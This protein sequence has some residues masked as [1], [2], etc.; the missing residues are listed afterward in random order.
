MA[1]LVAHVFEAEVV[2]EA[3]AYPLGKVAEGLARPTGVPAQQLQQQV[4][5][6]CDVYLRFH[7][8]GAGAR[9]GLHLQVLFE[10]LE[11]HLDGPPVPVQSANGLGRPSEVVGYQLKGPVFFRIVHGHLPQGVVRHPALHGPFPRQVYLHVR[12]KPRGR[13]FGQRPF[14]HHLVGGV[15]LDARHEVVPRLY[16][17][18]HQQ[19]V[20]VG[21]VLHYDVALL[22]HLLREAL[23]VVHPC[24]GY[25]HHVRQHRL[26]VQA[27]MYLYTPLCCPELCPVKQGQAE[28]HRGAVGDLD[29]FVLDVPY[30]LVGQALGLKD[31]TIV[32]QQAE[33]QVLEHPPVPLAVAVA[34]RR[35]GG[36]LRQAQVG[37]E[38][39]AHPYARRYVLQRVAPV[40]L[41]EHLGHQLVV[42]QVT[43]AVL[44][45]PVAV[46]G[47]LE[48]VARDKVD[49]LA[50]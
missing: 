1:D 5:Y 6:Q 16:S 33:V 20:V 25:V 29:R 43:A 21:P 14:G 26:A 12:D 7:G 31:A 32:P 9:E 3:D 2:V 10:G 8:V 30:H 35:A 42:G 36:A 50:E 41:S 38:R 45:R 19:E 46:H 34:H 37:D 22:E 23:A 49:Y 47:P 11:E 4:A 24:L 17:G 15:V 39:Q 28:T 44:V 13:V 27:R 18:L 48:Q 40:Q